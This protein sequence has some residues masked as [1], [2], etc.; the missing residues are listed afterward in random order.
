[1]SV[2][3]T[4]FPPSPTGDLHVGGARTALFNWLYARRQGGTFVLRIEDTDQERSTQAAVDSILD[5]LRWLGLDWDE[6]PFFQTQR[7]DRYRAAVELLLDQGKAYRCY[8]SKE[9]LEAMRAEQTALKEKPRYNGLWRGHTGPPPAGVAPTIRL[10]TPLEGQVVVQDTLRGPVV[11]QN[12][13]LDDLVIARADGMP[14]YHLTVVVDDM[15]MGITHIIRGD[16]HLN[17]TPRQIHIL[18]ALGAPLPTYTHVPM[19]LGPDGK[20]LSKRHGAASVLAFRDEGFLPAALLNYLVRLGWSHG[21][22]EVFSLD[23]MRALFDIADLNKGA[24]AL[25]YDKLRWLNQQY[26]MRMADNHLAEALRPFLAAAGLDPSLGPPLAEV[27]AA[28]KERAKT[29]AEMAHMARFCYTVGVEM[30]PK[31]AAKHLT[32]EAAPHLAAVRAGLAELPQWDAPAI[33][34]LLLAVAEACGVK[35]GKLAQPLRIAAT[36]GEASPPIDV[37]LALVGR[38]R[39][40]ARIDLA[41]ARCAQGLSG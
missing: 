18:N 34:A 39:T 12:S 8:C 26:M 37:T 23:E 15:D 9:E 40:L 17:N 25:D 24:T 7:L 2:V 29:M 41:L 13:E 19:I 22:Q 1:M 27:A 21:D 3:R 16:D 33:H 28:F 35:L 5:G 20:R 14:T 10:K 36:G 30:D 6:G 11:F 4:R 32:T 38:G 31:A